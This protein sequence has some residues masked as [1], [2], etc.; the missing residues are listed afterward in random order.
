MQFVK[1]GDFF[2]AVRITGPSHNLLQIR[3]SSS[4]Q[5]QIVCERLPATGDCRHAPLDEEEIVRAVQEGVAAANQELGSR[6]VISHI[7][8]VEND[9]RPEAVYGVMAKRI[10]Q[11]HHAGGEFALGSGSRP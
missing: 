8:Y 5:E 1:L 11:H 7:K 2:A 3:L 9:T 6:Y 10:L 4:E